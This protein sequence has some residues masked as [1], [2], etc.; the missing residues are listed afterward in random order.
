MDIHHVMAYATILISD[1]Q[2]MSHEAA[3]L[4]VPSI[5]YNDFA[6]RISVLEELETKY[7]LTFGISPD[8]TDKVFVKI[9]EL[10]SYQ[11]LYEEFQYRRQ[12][13]LNDKI[14][15]TAFITW[16]LENYPK[17]RKIMIQDPNYQFNFN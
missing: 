5:R 9:S 4:G 8:Q 10:L 3:M 14:D 13:M 6:G 7:H 2:S 17:S 11:N 15:V 16:F 12:L 1:S